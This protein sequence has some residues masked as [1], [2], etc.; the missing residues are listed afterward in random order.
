[1]LPVVYSKGNYPVLCTFNDKH[2]RISK[3]D[4]CPTYSSGFPSVWSRVTLNAY[5]A[6]YSLSSLQMLAS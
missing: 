4:K 5:K 6:K 3:C 1:M 2:G